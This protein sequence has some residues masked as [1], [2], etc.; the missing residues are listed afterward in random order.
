[1]P[2]VE[3]VFEAA[4]VFDTYNNG[5]IAVGELRNVMKNLG[6][7][8]DDATL[9]AMIKVAEPDS[10]QQVGWWLNGGTETAFTDR[11]GRV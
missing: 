3:E 11:G 4:A 8:L 2:S 1:M 7:G 10:E 6:E 9:E 5:Y